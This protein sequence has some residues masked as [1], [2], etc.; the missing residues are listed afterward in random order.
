MVSPHRASLLGSEKFPPDLADRQRPERLRRMRTDFLFPTPSFLTGIASLLNLSGNPGRYNHS[1]TGRE[2]DIRA[3]YSD[4][5]MI[6][7][8][9]EDVIK[10]VESQYAEA[11]AEQERLFDPD[12][13]MRAS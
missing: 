13:A 4:Y 6:G 1:R 12:E 2:A 10:V 7:Q 9:I 11:F 5:R 8:D 3:L